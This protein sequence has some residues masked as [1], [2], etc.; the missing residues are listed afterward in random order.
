VKIPGKITELNISE[1]TPWGTS[2]IFN[3]HFAIFN[4][5]LSAFAPR[6]FKALPDHSQIGNGRTQPLPNHYPSRKAL[7]FAAAKTGLFGLGLRSVP[8]FYAQIADLFSTSPGP[9]HFPLSSNSASPRFKTVPYWNLGVLWVLAFGVSPSYPSITHPLPTRQN[10]VSGALG[11]WRM[12][13]G[14][15]WGSTILE[16]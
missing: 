5:R 6:R 2:T 1:H 9:V 4:S 3:F 11:I 8:Q 14:I 7:T 16:R 10:S 13:L 15:W 12:H